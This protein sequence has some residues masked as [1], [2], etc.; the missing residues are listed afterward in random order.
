[1]RK[2]EKTRRFRKDT[3]GGAIF[4]AGQQVENRQSVHN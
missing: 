1:M 2:A 3:E 4:E